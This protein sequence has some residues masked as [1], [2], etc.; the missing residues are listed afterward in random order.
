MR[1]ACDAVEEGMLDREQAITTIDA[2]ALEALM[3]PTF[4]PEG[5]YEEVARGVAAS[6]GAAQGA[7]VFTAKEAVRRAA[8]GEDVILV[9]RFTEAEDVAGF[10]AARGILTAEGGKSSHAALVARG[11]GRPCV[12]GASTLEIDATNGVLKA[13]ETELRA[14]D[15]IAI[16]GSTGLVTVDEVEL[17]APGIGPE[18]ERVLG[19][20]DEIRRLGVRANADAA[21]DAER[22]RS[23]GAEGIGLCRTEHMFFGEDR[24]ELVREMFLSGARWRRAEARADDEEGDRSS[25]RAEAA[26]HE[27]LARLGELQRSDFAAIFRAMAGLAVTV[28]LLDPPLHEFLPVTHFEAAAR[29]AG[30][31]GEEAEEARARL[32]IARELEETNPMLGMRGIR[33]GV[34]FPELYE[35]QAK[36]IV[37]AMLEVDAAA[38][39]TTV[40]IM[41]PLVAYET[42]LA[43]VRGQIVAAV[44][45][46]LESAGERVDYE[47]GTMIELP[48]A[49]LVADR[50]AAHT[51]F[52]SFGTNDLT[53]TTDG[54]SRDDAEGAFLNVYLERGLLDR[55]P[56]ESLDTPGVGQLIEIA[57]RRG[58][59][60]RPDLRLGICGEHGG[61][62]ESILLLRAGRA[63][64]RQLLALPGADRA[65]RRRPGGDRG[66]GRAMIG[67][68]GDPDQRRLF[69]RFTRL[70][71]IPS[72]TG[73]ERA[74]ADD[75]L[76]ELRALGVEVAEDRSAGPARAGSGNLIARVPGTGD[77]W[78]S[79]FAHLD[80]VPEA[81]RIEVELADG[82]FRSRGETILGAD[83]KAAVAVLVELAA[84]HAGAPA[85]TGLEL[86]FT[87][88]EEEG[89]RGA[90]ELELGALR[91]PFGYVLDHASPIGELIA[92][93][94]T[95]QRLVAEFE[96]L[97]AH[98]GIRPEDGHS[99]IEAA[100]AAIA[101]MRLGRL[102]SETTANVGMVSGGTAPNVVAGRCRVEAEARSL[103][104]AKV[105]GATAAMLDACTWAASEH[106]CDVDLD[107][108]EV[109]RGYRQR[110]GSPVDEARARGDSSAAGSSHATSPPAV[111]ATRT[112]CSNAATTAC[113]LANG[114]EANHTAAGER[115]RRATDRDAR[116]VRG[117]RRARRRP[118]R[119][120][121]P[122][123]KLRR[124]VV[125][126]V[127]PLTVEVGGEHRPAWADSSLVGGGR[128]R[129]RGRGQHPGARPRA[130]LGRLRR[131]PRQPQPGALRRRGR[132]DPRD[133]A[134]LHLA[135]APGRAGRDRTRRARPRAE[136]PDRGHLAARPSG[137][138]RLGGGRGSP[139]AAA[140]LHPGRRRGAARDHCRA[141]CASCATA[142]C[143]AAT[144]PPG[145]PTAASRRRSASSAASTRPRGG[146][147]GT[148]SSSGPGP[149]SSARRPG[150]ATAAWRRST[151]A[152]AALALGLPTM[153]CPRMSS[154]DE[155][156]RHRGLSHHTASVLE[157]LLAPVRVPVPEAELEGWPLLGEG[158]R[159]GGR[160][161]RR[162][163][164]RT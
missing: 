94:P 89:L 157:L 86:V 109:F 47:I 140:R 34:V 145:P 18:F 100:A 55:S 103:D 17:I 4:D 32:A 88:A 116:R 96:G 147:A 19:W 39:R 78:V 82:V 162:R 91:A 141:T 105:A 113:L 110:P 28:R 79:F 41:L 72:P 68:R 53:Q 83:D 30:E 59:E 142:A 75:V 150:S 31:E 155:R 54:L 153:L 121:P 81:G 95:Y 80:T 120:E 138:D 123:L 69:G 90:K 112:R 51:D 10:H 158:E 56:F 152:H 159:A 98:A 70:C 5:D 85:P 73:E 144:S 12:A 128:G 23:F 151:R 21:E 43:L 22:A 33:L 66:R 125:V 52:F 161:R 44:E 29:E 38:E 127:D 133:Q 97:E 67:N 146:S 48:R 40:E 136:A 16:D 107:L 115:R 3:H 126:A 92:A 7:I 74:V 132:A 102:D 163:R 148:R 104:D 134:Q 25:D 36:A 61:D 111:A 64:L 63:R 143:S 93:A 49:C 156:E 101:A 164:S 71:E 9:R 57:V 50:I 1:F 11:M 42:E 135:P 99:A 122:M 20:A 45:A 76:G 37:E 2:G 13:G 26:F 15:R 106:G 77:R 60:T 130:R 6:P 129:R 117:D 58:R 119:G 137:A 124:G 46:T 154:C 8:D 160:R 114:T 14:G 62:P 139:R 149:G 65:R 84:R 108:T 24:E 118:S 87:V 27:A 35:M 131:R